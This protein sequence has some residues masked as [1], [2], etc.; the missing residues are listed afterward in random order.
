MEDIGVG[1]ST[2]PVV[3]FRLKEHI[4]PAPVEGSVPLLYASH[5]EGQETNWPS[6]AAKRGNA[7]LRNEETEKWLYPNGYY[8]VVRR[9]SSKEEKRRLVAG[10]VQPTSFPGVD[11]LGFENHLNVFHDHK[12]GLQKTWRMVSR[13][14]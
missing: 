7:I 13:H 12:A 3:D 6:D 4:I 5:F 8:A 11:K 1:L 2:G 9:F 14:F 10:I